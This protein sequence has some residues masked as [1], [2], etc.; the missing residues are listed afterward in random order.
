MAKRPKRYKCRTCGRFYLMRRRMMR[1]FCSPRCF[2]TYAK[3]AK[4]L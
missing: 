2:Q 4:A 3:I 1:Y